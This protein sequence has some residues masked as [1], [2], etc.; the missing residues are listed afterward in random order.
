MTNN[1]RRISAIAEYFVTTA[2]FFTCVFL[3]SLG[4]AAAQQ[5]GGNPQLGVRVQ[6]PVIRNFSIQ[7][8]VRVP[9]GGTM[10]L[11]GIN[12]SASG[13]VSSG[14]P[15]AAGPLSRPLRNSA[16]G[17]VSTAAGISVHTRIISQREIEARLMGEDAV[18]PYRLGE[19]VPLQPAPGRAA[20]VIPSTGQGA[21]LLV[22][23]PGDIDQL[24][25]FLTAN[26]GR[27]G[28]ASSSAKRR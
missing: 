24:A 4:P 18:D 21:Q 28:R 1:T 25:D 27:N 2:A 6:L 5:F 20:G 10:S 23:V 13:R 14:L 26:I 9:D 16:T 22:K 15:G 12:R 8:A 3:I 11:G 7:T 19:S 17:R